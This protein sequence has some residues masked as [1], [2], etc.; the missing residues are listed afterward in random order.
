MSKGAESSEANVEPCH[1]PVGVVTP[2]PLFF[3]I[4]IR[5]GDTDIN[6]AIVLHVKVRIYNGNSDSGGDVTRP[7][8]KYRLITFQYTDR[9]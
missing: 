5:I 8:H 2:E 6:I 1:M 3:F 7:C 4:F 9:S